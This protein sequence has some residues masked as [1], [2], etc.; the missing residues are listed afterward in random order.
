[1]AT[2]LDSLRER[3]L[4]AGVAPRHVR[5]YLTELADHLSDLRAEEEHAGRSK[6]DAES[7][8]LVR[9]GRIDDLSRAMICQRQFQ[10]W[11]ARAPWAMFTVAP[12]LALAAAYFVACLILWSGWR[13]LLPGSDTPFVPVDGLAVYYFGLGRMIYYVTPVA[14]G[15]G[16]CLLAARQRS[17]AAWPACGL[18]LTAL[19]AGTA[20][21]HA[22]R[23]AGF[24]GIGRVGMSFEL[25]PSL[26]A[27]AG[28]LSHVAAV[29][30]LIGLPWLA[31]RIQR[32]GSLSA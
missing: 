29:L 19:V 2:P 28:S 1:M 7:A 9:L 23:P 18:I 26:P 17:K 22:G 16:I 15:W 10:S 14:I 11:C 30:L 12:L 5:R 13:I 6:A 27:V 8:A 20:R 31:W 25:G 24:G 3:L 32:A 4:R 21:V